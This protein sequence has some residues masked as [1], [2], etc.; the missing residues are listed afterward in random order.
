VLADVP[1]RS[2]MDMGSAKNAYGVN[3]GSSG[4]II[5]RLS[6]AHDDEQSVINR[7]NHVHDDSQSTK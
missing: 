4:S 1:F 5:D 7:F 6:P 3:R 2:G